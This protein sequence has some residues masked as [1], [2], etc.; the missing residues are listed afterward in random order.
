M[1]VLILEYHAAIYGTSSS[2]VLMRAP[3]GRLLAKVF[4]GT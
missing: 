1:N 4:K 2:T 3:R